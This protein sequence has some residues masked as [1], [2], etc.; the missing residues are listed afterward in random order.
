M[1]GMMSG[2]SQGQDLGKIQGF[3]SAFKNEDRSG[4]E[5]KLKHVKKDFLVDVISYLIKE[6]DPKLVSSKIGESEDQVGDVFGDGEESQKFQLQSSQ[7]QSQSQ[8]QESGV[9]DVKTE[10]KICSFYLRG[11]CRHGKK[12]EECQFHHPKLCFK[13]RKNGKDGCQRGRKCKFA[14]VIFCKKDGCQGKECKFGYH[15]DKSSNKEVQG[16]PKPTQ[17]P[18]PPPPLPSF[19][20]KREGHGL[21]LQGSNQ[22]FLENLQRILHQTIA[23][24][25][26]SI[27]GNQSQF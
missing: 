2:Q 4:F 19:E 26:R 21:Q 1:D 23:E 6:M 14:H 18:P 22:H 9:N 25:M 8:Y 5:R 16:I 11:I 3:L 13:F 7:S 17:T 15:L 24:A 27:I 12:G 20:S 10:K